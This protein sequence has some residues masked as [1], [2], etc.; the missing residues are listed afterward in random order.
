MSAGAAGRIGVFA[1][2][3][4]LGTGV[5]APAA[6]ADTAGIIAPQ[7][8]PH[9]PADGWQAGTC[10]TDTPTCTVDTPEKFFKEAAGHPQKGFTQFI[11]KSKPGLVGP[12]EPIGSLKTVRV[13][14]PAG[15][16]VNPQATEQCTQEEFEGNPALQCPLAAVGTSLV[17][18]SVLGV[19]APVPISATV[20][21]IE[22]PVGEPARFGFNLAGN[23]I[24]LRADVAWDGDYHEGFTIDVPAVPL[25][26]GLILKNRLVFEGRSGDG[27]FITTPSTCF[28]PEQPPTEGVYSTYLLASSIAEENEA[29]YTFPQSAFPAFE[30]PLPPGEKPLDCGGIPYDPSIGVDPGTAQTDSPTGIAADVEV[31]H[32]LGGANRESS[33]TKQ[34]KVTL[35]LGMGLNPS[36]ATSLQTCTDAQFGKGTRSPVACPPASKVGVASVDTPPLP[37]G[38]LSGDVYVG[39]QLSRDPTSGDEY[40]IFVDLESARYGISARLVGSVSADPQTGQLTTTFDDKQLGGLPQV[41]FSS[42]RLDLDDGPTAVLTSPGSCGPS[43]ATT[44]M[45]PWSGN[46]PETR[47]DEFTLTTAPGGGPCPR[48]LAERPFEPGFGAGTA[49]P[50]AGA[51]SPLHMDIVRADGN[52]ELKGV[53]VTLPPGLT[54]KLAGVRYCP[55]ASLAAAAANSGAAEAAAP[56]CPVSSL[57]GRADIAAGSGPSPIRIGGKVFLAGPYKEAPLSLAVVTPATAG[58]FDLGAVVV[59]VALF[60][61]PRTAQVRAVSDPVPHVYGGAL[62]DIRSV[63]VG[64]DRHNFSLNPTNCSPF[65]FSGTLLGGGA[66][67]ADPAAFVPKPVTAPF[68]V[69]DCDALGFQPKLF[70]RAFGATRRAKNPKLRAVLI[71]RPGDANIGRAAVTLPRSLFLDQSSISNVCTRVQFAAH[72]CPKDS[73][74]GYAQADTPLLDGPLKGPVY[75]RSSDNTL[76]DLV[77]ALHGQV[78]VELAGRTDSVHGRIRNTFDVVPDVPVSKFTLTVRGG[79]NGLLVNSRNLCPSKPRAGKA[80]GKGPRVPLRALVRF[81]GQN[82]KKANMRPKLR[83]PC[84]KRPKGRAGVYPPFGAANH[85]HVTADRLASRVGA[86]DAFGSDRC[87]EQPRG[88]GADA[89]RAAAGAGGG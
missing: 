68:Q 36:A 54:A 60:V 43:T 61:D 8:D 50:K 63:S 88:A 15:V 55:E 79:A 65:A 58:P 49:K 40:R 57:I 25:V 46:P 9:T 38:S 30:S 39:Q 53:D 44:R 17:T 81:K 59:R 23:N 21:N 66:N 10:V 64:L 80:G 42:F 69:S 86:P 31:P 22:P 29:G 14:L 26:E 7:N 72:D 45:T 51:F 13:D 85:R 47:S 6:S 27:T 18:G 67:P 74:Y 75:L 62:L 41:P 5:W 11:V 35:P 52:Q 78:D 24:Y 2:V 33:Q 28:D 16:S 73:V 89:A 77:A 70:L 48:T 56:S 20:Y 83:T 71:A 12:E 76:P 87:L 37:D 1:A 3:L 32:I 34:A 19:P 4:A 84:T 82:G